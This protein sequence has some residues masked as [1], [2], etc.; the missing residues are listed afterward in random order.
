MFFAGY[1]QNEGWELYAEGLT[2]KINEYNNNS[3]LFLYPNP[4]S[5]SVS[6][7]VPTELVGKCWSLYDQT[8]R[9]QQSGV[10]SSTDSEINLES[11]NP[12]IYIMRSDET[13]PIKIIKE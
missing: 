3:S 8:G 9:F 13:V 10:N 6:I 4:T 2:A 1:T 11:Y 5:S 7:K 12:G